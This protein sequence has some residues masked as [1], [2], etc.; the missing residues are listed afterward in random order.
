M[1]KLGNDQ[2]A[3]KADNR[4]TSNQMNF[5]HIELK[6]QMASLNVEIDAVKTSQ[7][8]IN[9]K[10]EENVQTTRILKIS[11][12]KLDEKCENMEDNTRYLHDKCNFLENQI[13][14]SVIQV[15]LQ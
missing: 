2:S 15:R 11:Q 1:E 12:K 9:Y 7:E 13:F 5:N 10:F 14:L 8:W 3:I 6:N 4:K